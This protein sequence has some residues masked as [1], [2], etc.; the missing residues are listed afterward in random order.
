MKY[1]T[2]F[3]LLAL[4]GCTTF[5]ATVDGA[6]GVVNETVASIG[7]GVA[8]VTSAVG[9]D[10]TDTVTYA[11]DGTA[12]GIRILSALRPELHET[13]GTV[14]VRS[15]V[16]GHPLHRFL[17]QPAAQL[18]L[19]IHADQSQVQPEDGHCPLLEQPVAFRQ[20]EEVDDE[21][22]APPTAS[23]PGGRYRD[24]AL[25]ADELLGI[26]VHHSHGINQQM[27]LCCVPGRFHRVIPETFNWKPVSLQ[28]GVARLA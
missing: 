1:L 14:G 19:M 7:N 26:V 15:G 23:R 22:T 21:P 4:A 28:R 27:S 12:E 9:K 13:P 8:G 2:P 18:V 16:A 25:K 5:N 24:Y 20:L 11:A 3:L 6:Q 10:V 17:R